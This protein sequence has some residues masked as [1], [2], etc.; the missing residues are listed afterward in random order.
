MAQVY[1]KASGWNMSRG[2]TENL[3]RQLFG[4]IQRF[5]KPTDSGPMFN[6]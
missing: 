4:R 2:Q 6:C 1:C 5:C 3:T